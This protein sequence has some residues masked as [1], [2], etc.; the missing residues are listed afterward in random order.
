MSERLPAS[1]ATVT[2]AEACDILDARR[3]PVNASERE[4]R[5]GT[6]PYYGATGQVGWIDGHLFDE[7]LILL[8]EDGAPFFDPVRRKAYIIRGR[9]WVNNHAHVLRAREGI[10]NAWVMH[11]LNALDYRP[12]VSGSTRLKLPQ[13]PMRQI[14]LLVPPLAEQRRIVAALEEHFSDLDAAVASLERARANLRRYRSAV[15]DAA[16]QAGAERW[17]W[18]AFG[19]HIASIE[20]GASFRCQERPP[21]P[22]E[23]GVVKVSAVTWGHYDEDE[24][25]T[26]TQRERI[27]ERLMVRSGDF[28]F[29]RAN[30][31]K[32][33]GACVIAERVSR[34]VMLSDK[35][36][37]FRFRDLDSRWALLVLRSAHGR[38]EIERL[39]TGNQESMR[40]IG[41]KRIRAIRI[42]VPNTAEQQ[43]IVA[44]VESRLAVADRTAAD[45]EVQL[46]RA[47][48]LRQSILQCAFAGRLVPQ[49]P[50]DEPASALLTRVRA[51]R[52]A[53]ASPRR[54]RQTRR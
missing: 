13:G 48:S 44:E 49:D 21:G 43:E 24:S 51:E 5:Q 26:V 32:L 46:A 19:E 16:I 47:A 45:I 36:L 37:R 30:T 1:W 50:D 11:Q 8:G 38:S 28:L 31:I 20:A 15:Q 2:L 17:E 4:Q 7:E 3:V 53:S 29:S 6:V 25:K 35:I 39:A 40:N 14:P 34:R 18:K 54:P 23:V 41:Q 52:Q 22:N 27:D 10:L 33:V 9:S 42:P 12:Y